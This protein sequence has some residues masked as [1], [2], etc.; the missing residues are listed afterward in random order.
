[1][2]QMIDVKT[3]SEEYLTKLKELCK[4]STQVVGW[5]AHGYDRTV[6]GP[7]CRWFTC[8]EVSPEYQKHVASVYDEVEYCAAAMNSMPALLELLDQKEAKI[9]ELKADMVRMIES[10]TTRSIYGSEQAKHRKTPR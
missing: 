9:K 7:F 8:S 6:R 5:Y 3:L 2:S 1:M 10:D 4:K